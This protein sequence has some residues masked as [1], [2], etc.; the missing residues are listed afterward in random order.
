VGTS[1]SDARA[2]CIFP[3]VAERRVLQ[4]LAMFVGT[5]SVLPGLGRCDGTTEDA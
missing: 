2:F 1:K 4:K 3:D 5:V